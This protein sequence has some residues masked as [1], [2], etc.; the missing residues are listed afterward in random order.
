MAEQ[1]VPTEVQAAG[2]CAVAALAALIMHL[3]RIKAFDELAKSSAILPYDVR[4]LRT[5]AFRREGS[6]P[7]LALKPSHAAHLPAIVEAIP[8]QTSLISPKKFQGQC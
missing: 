4:P 5:S 3:K 8:L 1:A 7:L 6:R 2:N